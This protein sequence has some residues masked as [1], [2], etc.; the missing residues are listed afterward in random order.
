MGEMDLELKSYRV[1]KV[2][3]LGGTVRL[4]AVDRVTATLSIK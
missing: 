2:V 1:L 4:E 3:N